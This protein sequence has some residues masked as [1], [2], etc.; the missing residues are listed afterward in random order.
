MFAEI[1][2]K[3]LA[4]ELQISD[5]HE[6]AKQAD[7]SYFDLL[8]VQYDTLPELVNPGISG[9]LAFSALLDFF[10]CQQEMP[11]QAIL[12]FLAVID[13]VCQRALKMLETQG[14]AAKIKPLIND[15]FRYG[16][17]TDIYAIDDLASKQLLAFVAEQGD[18]FYGTFVFDQ[19]AG[20]RS[21]LSINPS[22]ARK[23][24]E[25]NDDC[26]LITGGTYP[27]FYRGNIALHATI[28]IPRSE[29]T[30]DMTRAEMIASQYQG[31]KIPLRAVVLYRVVPDTDSR[32]SAAICLELQ[33]DFPNYYRNAIGLAD[34]RE[35]LHVT[36]SVIRRS[37]N[38]HITNL[39]ELYEEIKMGQQSRLTKVLNI[40]ADISV[41]SDTNKSSVVAGVHQ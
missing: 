9:L 22:V 13:E 12:D 35:R 33:S 6:W 25:Y 23:I 11:S 41:Q 26:K 7:L 28:V 1:K 31:K 38:P 20:G 30:F 27:F 36:L 4:H 19:S 24:M 5:L 40:L 18:A 29:V 10:K 8:Q 39:T 34:L 2:R 37:K 14:M 3:L 15:L 16:V 17:T 21:Y 32:M